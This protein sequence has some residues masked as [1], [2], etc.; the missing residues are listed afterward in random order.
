MK[1]IVVPPVILV[2]NNELLS[3]AVWARLYVPQCINRRVDTLM[4][5]WRFDDITL[6]KKNIMTNVGKSIN[7]YNDSLTH[8]EKIWLNKE[9]DNYV[10][11]ISILRH[12]DTSNRNG[13]ELLL[14]RF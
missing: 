6:L 4:R 5:L 1:I 11:K 8:K 13:A 7:A 14:T 2:P 3:L 12:S 9:R 10:A